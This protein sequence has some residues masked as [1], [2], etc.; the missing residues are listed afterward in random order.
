MIFSNFLLGLAC[1]GAASWPGLACLASLAG[2]PGFAGLA[3][4]AL[5]CLA[6][7]ALAG[8]PARRSYF[9][10]WTIQELSGNY[11]GFNW[12]L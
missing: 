3:W 6:S 5:S 11:R 12:E 2:L 8:W 9:S 4:L 7:L 10:I 1:L